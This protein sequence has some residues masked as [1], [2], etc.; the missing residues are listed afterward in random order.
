MQENVGKRELEP[1][2]DRGSQ[3]GGLPIQMEGAR[4][5]INPK[6]LPLHCPN[7][8]FH[9]F[10]FKPHFF[11]SIARFIGQVKMSCSY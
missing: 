8:F 6:M 11:S 10:L 9:F 3:I 5:N 4:E 7:F 1:D 2:M